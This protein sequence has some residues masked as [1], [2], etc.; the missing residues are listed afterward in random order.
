MTKESDG[1][2]QIIRAGPEQLRHRAA[3]VFVE[4]HFD[5]VLSSGDQRDR[6]TGV[7]GGPV[8]GPVVDDELIVDPQTHAVVGNGVERHVL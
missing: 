5:R 4:F 1:S 2:F 7:F 3:G 6:C 8:I